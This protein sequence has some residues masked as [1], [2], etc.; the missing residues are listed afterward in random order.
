MHFTSN[1]CRIT[2][3]F[4]A[5]S[6]VIQW[7]PS[8]FKLQGDMWL[9]VPS[10]PSYSSHRMTR[11]SQQFG[12]IHRSGELFF[13]TPYSLSFWMYC[14]IESDLSCFFSEDFSYWQSSCVSRVFLLERYQN[15]PCFHELKTF[16]F[17]AEKHE[18]TKVSLNVSIK[19]VFCISSEFPCFYFYW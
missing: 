18:W 7:Q 9:N 13:K 4:T 10:V 8:C 6:G 2:L 1:N 14:I 19:V 11:R 17:I 16:H 12:S 3:H 5:S 15:Y